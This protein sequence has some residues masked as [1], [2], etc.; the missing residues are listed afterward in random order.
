[1]FFRRLLIM[2]LTTSLGALTLGVTGAVVG[3]VTDSELAVRA[4]QAPAA[5]GASAQK[6]SPRIDWQ[7]CRSRAL[8][9][10]GG[11]C[12]RV[13]VPMDYDDPSAGKIS[14]AVSRLRHTTTRSQGVMLVNPGGPGA[15]GLELAL[16]K[17]TMP[18]NS[19]RSFDWIGFDPRG[20]GA[21]RPAL[22]CRPWYFH[23]DRPAYVPRNEADER[24]WL[25]RSRHYAR[26][27]AKYGRL[28]DN[29]TT[30]DM[31]RDVDQIR[32]ALRQ[33]RISWYGY[34]YGTY[35]G[36]VYATLFPHRV[37]RM[38]LDSNVD[39]RN[40]WY[41]ANLEQNRAFQPA[42]TKFFAWVA[43]HRSTYHLGRS[44]RQVQRTY[45]RVR[46]QLDRRPAA[47]RLGPSEFDDAALVAAYAPTAW[48]VVG[49]A[50]AAWVN[51]GNPRP[52]L[53]L[54]RWWDTPGDDNL[55]AGYLAVFCTE[56]TWPNWE[57]TRADARRLHRVSPI[58]TWAN[59]WFNAPC[60]FWPAESTAPV[61]VDGHQVRALLIGQT[62]DAATPFQGSLETRGRFPKSALVAVRGG[63]AHAASP[64]GGRCVR[65]AIAAYLEKGVLPPREP[66][67]RADLLCPAPRLPTP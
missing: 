8:R 7:R 22:S 25:R 54:W 53:G 46:R 13:R 37:K 29:M 36:Q 31:A 42:F 24:E 2:S 51:Q 18:R 66:G 50:L 26:G 34:S 4:E 41:E 63:Y 35:I 3:A 56:G 61:D 39:P 32:R 60:L 12:G 10:A 15:P 30:A 1:M 27:C 59:T 48:P 5:S 43:T 64:G 19:G 45:L 65:R 67:R 6:A 14:L 40:V 21:S 52:L 17:R 33:E 20:A 38:V 11:Q 23:A 47:G 62:E 44:A 16:L 9:R 49:A 58:I 55:F 57:Q 28:L